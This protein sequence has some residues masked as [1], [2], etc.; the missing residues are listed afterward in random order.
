MNLDFENG[1]KNEFKD[2]NEK[3]SSWS[4][5]R[6]SHKIDFKAVWP[7]KGHA[8]SVGVKIE[9]ISNSDENSKLYAVFQKWIF[10]D[11]VIHRLI[12]MIKRRAENLKEWKISEIF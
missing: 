9:T 10:Y 6:I 12:S 8:T 11:N 7:I 4:R 3:S 2:K 5:N 1:C